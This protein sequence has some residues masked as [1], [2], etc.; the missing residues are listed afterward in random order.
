[1]KPPSLSDFIGVPST[2]RQIATCA[3]AIGQAQ[4]INPTFLAERPKVEVNSQHL[5]NEMLN[6]TQ[7]LAGRSHPGPPLPQVQ[8]SLFVGRY[9]T[10][11][12]H[13]AIRR[14]CGGMPL[15]PS[16]MWH[17]AFRRHALQRKCRFWPPIIAR[18]AALDPPSRYNHRHDRPVCADCWSI[19]VPVRSPLKRVATAD[20]LS[21]CPSSRNR[22]SNFGSS[23][24]S[25]GEIV[26]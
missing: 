24:L 2:T 23:G 19:I 20:G 22:L 8:P 26:G 6:S 10:S 25:V 4:P 11:V 16:G 1:M 9:V 12:R 3:R 21:Q 14:H 5:R 18:S 7:P 15:N 13:S 17:L